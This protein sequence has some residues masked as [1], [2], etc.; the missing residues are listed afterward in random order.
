MSSRPGGPQRSDIIS[1]LQVYKDGAAV[2]GNA[3]V[4]GGTGPRNFLEK[5]VEHGIPR[6]A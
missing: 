6:P 3:P 4:H 1:Y 2:A 5:R